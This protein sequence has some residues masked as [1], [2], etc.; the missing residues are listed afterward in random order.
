V[1]GLSPPPPGTPRLTESHWDLVLKDVLEFDGGQSL[2]AAYVAPP[3]GS[4]ATHASGIDKKLS[5]AN[6]RQ[7]CW[8]E[9]W[10]MRGTRTE[11]DA[12]GRVRWLCAFKRKGAPQKLVEVIVD[13][14]DKYL[15][16]TLWAGDGSPPNRGQPWPASSGMMG[17]AW[18]SPTGATRPAEAARRGLSPPPPPPRGTVGR[19]FEADAA[20]ASAAGDGSGAGGSDR[21]H[22]EL[23]AVMLYRSLRVWTPFDKEA[24]AAVGARDSGRGGAATQP[25]ER[26]AAGGRSGGL[27]RGGRAA[28]DARRTPGTDVGARDLWAPD[29]R[30]AE[31]PAPEVSP[32]PL[33]GGF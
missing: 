7:A 32:P 22:R 2:R 33:G 20:G 15:W 3:I 26:A 6:S 1:T 18:R 31:H 29:S 10:C 23:R 28:K 27:G 21:A 12:Q 19:Y 5:G 9:P 24:G 14:S 17:A 13:D 30:D 16:R 25:S 11:D 8:N 4:F